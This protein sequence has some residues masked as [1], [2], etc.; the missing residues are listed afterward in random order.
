[1]QACQDAHRKPLIDLCQAVIVRIIGCRSAGLRCVVQAD[2]I[3]ARLN[4]RLL[5]SERHEL[6]ISC[7][8]SVQRSLVRAHHFL[9][10]QP[11]TASASCTLLAPTARCMPLN[12][13][14]SRQVPESRPQTL[15]AR[16]GPTSMPTNAQGTSRACSTQVSRLSMLHGD[17]I[18]SMSTQYLP[19]HLLEDL[20]LQLLTDLMQSKHRT[21]TCGHE[22]TKLWR[23]H[24]VNAA[25]D[26]RQSPMLHINTRFRSMFAAVS[27][28]V[29]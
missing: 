6:H 27:Q 4:V 1:M 19:M 11:S 17:T 5:F 15:H 23:K 21:L 10:T 22:G 7:H 25:E 28:A 18:A 2:G 12:L 3:Q 24:V 13:P 8:N 16:R 29:M 14:R 9:Q 20:L 26:R